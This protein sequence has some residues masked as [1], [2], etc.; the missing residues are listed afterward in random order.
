MNMTA[1]LVWQKGAIIPGYDPAEWRRDDF[2][3]AMS[4]TMYGNRSSD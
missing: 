1:V 4:F 2:G 3:Y